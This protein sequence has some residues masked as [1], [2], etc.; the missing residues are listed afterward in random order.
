MLYAS[1]PILI[2]AYM[3]TGKTTFALSNFYVSW[4]VLEYLVTKVVRYLLTTCL[5]REVLLSNMVITTE[6]AHETN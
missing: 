5:E 2:R 6:T 4:N 1:A 3:V